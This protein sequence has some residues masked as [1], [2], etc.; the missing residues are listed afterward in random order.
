MSTNCSS[1]REVIT[2]ASD[3]ISCKVCKNTLHFYCCGFR[4][5]NFRKT[6]KETKNSWTCDECK[7]SKTSTAADSNKSFQK[8]ILDQ[9]QEF[10]RSLDF[11]S[12]VLEE[13]V[14]SNKNLQ[15]E[16]Q[17]I[18]KENYQ[19]IEENKQL[20]TQIAEIKNDVIDL[21]QYSRRLNVEIANLPECEN[22]NI[23]SIMESLM[24]ALETDQ[25]KDLVTYHRVPTISKTKIKPIVV[26]FTS[27]TTKNNFLKIAK[28]KK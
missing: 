8:E 18:K 7:S 28:Q 1:C 10:K 2:E 14:K 23:T 13:V 25:M 6:S 20:K 26:Q 4:E 22:E 5:A 9:L 17:N 21:Q 16:L 11:N 15:E 24:V 27:I 12:K 19:L 3:C